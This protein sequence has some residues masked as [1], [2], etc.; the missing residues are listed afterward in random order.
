MF[1]GKII[2]LAKKHGWKEQAC[3]ATGFSGSFGTNF[4]KDG[5]V[6]SVS[7]VEEGHM[8]YPDI[9]LSLRKKIIT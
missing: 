5:T 3:G 2:Q 9:A 6:L 8:T 4:F 7:V 1:L